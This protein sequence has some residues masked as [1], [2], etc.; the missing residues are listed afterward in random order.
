[1][2]GIQ[3]NWIFGK[4]SL[5]LLISIYAILWAWFYLFPDSQYIYTF[6]FY[7]VGCFIVGPINTIFAYFFAN[8]L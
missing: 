3:F 8:F 6:V 2:K 4:N 7:F 1:M 5:V